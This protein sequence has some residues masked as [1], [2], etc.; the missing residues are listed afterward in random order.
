MHYACPVSVAANECKKGRNLTKDVRFWHIVA[1]WLSQHGKE[2][3]CV[4]IYTLVGISKGIF[5]LVP[6]G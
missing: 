5:A 1:V 4:I 6:S 2:R 3:C